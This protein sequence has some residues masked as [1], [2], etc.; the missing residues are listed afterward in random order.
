[1]GSW[2]LPRQF[3][4]LQTR[5]T[6][7]TKIRTAIANR[8]HGFCSLHVCTCGYFLVS[9]SLGQE[10]W[11]STSPSLTPRDMICAR[12][13]PGSSPGAATKIIV[14]DEAWLQ[15]Q[16][17]APGIIVRRPSCSLSV[18]YF[19]ADVS[20]VSSASIGKVFFLPIF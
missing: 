17:Q 5:Q 7:K 15:I 4:L 2:F 18:S 16:A 1:M 11:Y 3:K 6:Q 20:V 14:A 13:A 8:C 9:D 10:S 19:T 12:P